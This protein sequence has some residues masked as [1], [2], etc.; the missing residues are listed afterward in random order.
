MTQKQTVFMTWIRKAWQ[1]DHARTLIGSI[2]TFGGE[3]NKCPIWIFEVDPDHVSCSSLEGE[4]IHVFSLEVPEILMNYYYGDKVFA[5]AQAEMMV[6]STVRSLILLA[7]ENLII[8]P[9]MLFDIRDSQDV[10]VR[11]VHIKNVGLSYDEPLDDYWRGVYSAIGIDD[12][13]PTVESYVDRKRLRA[14]F[15][16]AAFSINPA[17][18]LLNQWLKYF[19]EL[20]NDREYQESTCQDDWHKVFLHQ[21]V[22]ST[23]I[24][25]VQTAGGVRIL[26]PDYIYPYNL[27]TSVQVERRAEVLNDLT[28]IYYEDRIL[29]PDQMTDVIIQ[30][31]LRSW[32]KKIT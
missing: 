10:A 27:H 15:N 29:D 30:E 2:R 12:V 31:P 6:D 14:Y 26:P 25:G 19:Q 21:A 11:P 28:S 7:T 1:R 16:S 17:K 32:L 20:V 24:A 13:V 9:P 8:R 3:L 22:L 23:L 4:D 18:G 5:C